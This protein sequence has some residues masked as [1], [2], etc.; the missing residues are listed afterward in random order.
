MNLKKNKIKS[1]RSGYSWQCTYWF[2]SRS[3]I[4]RG[5]IN[6]DLKIYMFTYF[7][8]NKIFYSHCTSNTT[9]DK[10]WKVSFDKYFIEVNFLNR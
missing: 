8:H 9:L 4:H 7:Y 1:L 5:Q 2:R 6:H 10:F 3:Q